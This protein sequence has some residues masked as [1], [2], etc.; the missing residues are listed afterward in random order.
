MNKF[1]KILILTSLL[2]LF[3]LSGVVSAADCPLVSTL[4]QCAYVEYKVK[5]NSGNAKW[6][7]VYNDYPVC[8]GNELG[9][10]SGGDGSSYKATGD[11]RFI[12]NVEITG[13]SV[14]KS[15][16]K[17]GDALTFTVNLRNKGQS[18]CTIY[19]GGAVT[20][21]DSTYC[22]TEL[23]SKY[24]GYS[25]TGSV[26]LSWTVPYT[27][28]CYGFTT[29]VWNNC[30]G[31]CSGNPCYSDGCCEG[32]QTSYSTSNLF[33]ISQNSPPTLSNGYVTPTSGD[34]STQFIYY[35]TYKD[36][37][38]D[39]PSIARIYIDGTSYDLSYLSGSYAGGADY[40][41]YKTLSTGNHNYYFYFS[42]GKGGE[43]TSGTYSGPSVNYDA[44]S[45]ASFSPPS[46]TKSP[47]SLLS[48]SITV[49]N[50]GTSTRSFWTGLSYQKPDGTWYDVPPKQTN[51]I[52][53]NSQQTLT[54]DWNLPSNAPSGTYNAR[55]AVWNGY[56]PSANLM[57][58]PKYDN[59]DVS[60]FT[61]SS[62]T[63]S[64][65]DA[66]CGSS[67][68]CTNCNDKDGCD[69]GYYKNYYCSGTSCAFSSSCTE[70]CCD[71][72]HGNSN[73]YCSGGTCYPPPDICSSYTSCST[74]TAQSGCGWSLSRNKCYKGSGSGSDNGLSSGSDWTWGS[75]QCVKKCSD[76]TPYGSCSSIKPKYCS[77]GSLV[78][79]CEICGCPTDQICASTGS[80]A[81]Y[82]PDIA[83]T[84]ISISPSSP[85]ESD[86]VT[87]T[88]TFKNT[89]ASTSKT[90]YTKLYIDGSFEKDWYTSGLD[91]GS[92]T[93][94]SYTK[95]LF[96]GSHKIKVVTD[97][98]SAVSDSD[99]N[100]NILEKEITVSP[101][102]SAQITKVSDI[103][104]IFT[105][106][107]YF[108]P[109]VYIKNSGA[110]AAF[111]VEADEPE[112]T[113]IGD[114]YADKS[115]NSKE[116]TLSSGEE[117]YVAFRIK[118]YGLALDRNLYFKL[119]DSGGNKLD[120]KTILVKAPDT[121]EL[122]VQL[123]DEK[124][125]KLSGVIH[126]YD[127]KGKEAGYSSTGYYNSFIPIGEYKIKGK[128][129][130]LTAE[131][132]I[133]LT[134]GER[135]EVS[136]ILIKQ[137]GDGTRYGECS[138]K[139]TGKY[140][141]KGE[142][143][144]NC[145]KCG[146]PSG[147]ICSGK[148]CIEKP[149]CIANEEC[150]N[151]EI[152]SSDGKCE[153]AKL[154]LVFVPITWKDMKIFD[155]TVDV[156]AHN[157]ITALGECGSAIRVIKLHSDCNVSVTGSCANLR[158]IRRCV[159][160]SLFIHEIVRVVGLDDTDVLP[161]DN[162]YSCKEESAVFVDGSMEKFTTAHELGHTFGLCD[163]AYGICQNRICG[164][165]YSRCYN[166][167]Q[168]LFGCKGDGQTDCNFDFRSNLCSPY[169]ICNSGNPCQVINPVC[170]DCCPN[171]P[172]PNSI[173]NARTSLREV[174][175]GNGL[176]H[177]HR[178]LGC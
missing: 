20:K 173:M 46:G 158:E 154:V 59:K 149:P 171:A 33:C 139:E 16:P 144:D 123:V 100:N 96:A 83:V 172:S 97:T 38:N 133:T 41:Y 8:V 79:K 11:Y 114:K 57:V 47:G 103:P 54:F 95:K 76:G 22:N 136:L 157:F 145:Q 39:A 99:R 3:A 9:G 93:T 162:G 78:D 30:W 175:F 67:P 178:E 110:A 105:L 45:I 75:S 117:N 7:T 176:S 122:T 111:R 130:D 109:K 126:M 84:D 115:D 163:E 61:V 131:K 32:R 60:A 159:S 165:G 155:S 140:C 153:K 31:G 88:F 116:T 168:V 135:E 10:T 108:Y 24:L 127:S 161:N 29:G 63:C 142:L 71:L 52:S 74:C 77:S 70:T 44:A 119:Y 56:N 58:E 36:P 43:V 51:S 17:Y 53:P 150:K 170:S 6:E 82:S 134:K 164:S 23:K 28:G 19:V 15:S 91:G 147:K 85:K 141:E 102:T 37:D 143:T 1:K 98:G 169:P 2:S 12:Y 66:S 26:S 94:G 64:G 69:G 177:L 118:F 4:P 18:S 65:T 73:A 89:G 72:Y 13:V 68:P 48:S 50:T 106:D 138:I 80:C 152:C 156:Q 92:T 104:D 128:S 174:T 112:G 129:G 34:T 125:N 27:S 137:C 166:W 25:T 81:S 5:D 121:G 40:K 124:G 148:M 49:K 101:T 35:V 146:C 151:D 21:P 87:I 132:S 14:S 160:S 90:F 120:E 55:T 62:P 167:T 113:V 86:S 42:D 107:E